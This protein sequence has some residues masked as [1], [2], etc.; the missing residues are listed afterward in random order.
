MA[1][2]E[3]ITRIISWP[4]VRK[5][6]DGGDSKWPPQLKSQ[7]QPCHVRQEGEALAIHFSEP[8]YKHIGNL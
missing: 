8:N 3:P 4:P 7:N 1:P 2:M 5:F 6:M